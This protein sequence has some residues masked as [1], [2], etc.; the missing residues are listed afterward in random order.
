M[1]QQKEYFIAYL[2]VLFL[3]TTILS[4]CG[5]S[6]K[7][8][9]TQTDTEL[10]DQ[11]KRYYEQGDYKKSLQYFLY[12]KDHFLR[13]PYAGTTR[14]YAGESYFALKKYE[15]AV[16]EY[17]SFLSFFP[18][19][20]NAAAA[21]YK[22]GVCY[23]NQSLGP[24]R[25]QTM[26]QNALTELQNVRLNYPE[27]E[28]YAGKAEEKI[29]ETKNKLAL[30]EFVVA[31]FYR[32]EKRYTAS[33]HRLTYL[34][35]EYPDSNLY[36]D[37]VFT[38]GLNY[39]DLEQPEKAKEQFLSFIQH[40]PENQHV[41]K[42]KKQLAR[43]GVTNIPEPVSQTYPLSQQPSSLEGY[44]VLKRDN[45]V[46]IDLTRDDGIK[47]GMILEVYRK[48]TFI[49]TIRIIE[50]QEGFSIGEIES[51]TSNTVIEEEDRV[52]FPNTERK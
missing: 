19:D 17:K 35:T 51:L 21:Q 27:N 42:A 30:H 33:N 36:G 26:I 52:L 49:G 14:F 48:N 11:G 37:A 28:G 23:L 22:L 45:T 5:G 38:L 41:S 1:Q 6:L 46:F 7:I 15:D 34:M 12:L 47:E 18:N 43:L 24:D 9:E 13:S 8:M 39:L 32:K 25:D 2:C 4:G 50:I 3:V 16:I 10:F 20:P 31:E 29:E 40:Y 44:V